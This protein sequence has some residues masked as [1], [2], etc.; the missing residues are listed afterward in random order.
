MRCHLPG[1]GAG[2]HHLPDQNGE[3]RKTSPNIG[4][5]EG[6]GRGPAVF[7]L[8]VGLILRYFQ[9]QFEALESKLLGYFNN[10][11]IVMNGFTANTRARTTLMVEE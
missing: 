7:S 9:G 5:H 8:P 10:L 4:T 1:E 11:T 6:D 3:R 2:G